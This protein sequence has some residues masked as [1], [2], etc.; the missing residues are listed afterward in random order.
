LSHP[1]LSTIHFPMEPVQEKEWPYTVQDLCYISKLIID[2]TIEGYCKETDFKGIVEWNI[3]ERAA[4]LGD[5][6]LLWNSLED[7]VW[8]QT[9][10]RISRHSLSSTE[11]YM[12]P[13][14]PTP[15][16]TTRLQEWF[17]R[18][19]SM[20]IGDI[21]HIISQG[22]QLKPGY[23]KNVVWIEAVAKARPDDPMYWSSTEEVTDSSDNESPVSTYSGSPPRHSPM[24]PQVL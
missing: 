12:Q 17:E 15:I 6:A 8:N 3:P 24:H 11:W 1:R 18:D 16:M 14:T 23:Y 20:C 7:A 2:F 19:G 10:I 4:T 13:S 9:R 21:Q 22:A 5:S